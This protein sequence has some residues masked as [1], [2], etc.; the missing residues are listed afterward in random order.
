MPVQPTPI[1]PVEIKNSAAQPAEPRPIEIPPLRAPEIRP[2]EIRQTFTPQVE[3]SLAASSEI[4]VAQVAEPVLKQP[5]V[6][7]FRVNEVLVPK[8]S[9]ITESFRLA[10][11]RFSS[12]CKSAWLGL[13]SMGA[14]AKEQSLRRARSF[15]LGPRLLDAGKQGQH[16]VRGGWSRTG[17]YVRTAGGALGS[18]SRTG[19]ARMRQA[20]LKVRASSASAA[21]DVVRRA[22]HQPATPSRIRMLIAASVLRARIMAAQQLSAWRIRREQVA[23]DSRFWTSMTMAA[24]AAIIALVIVS[25]VPHYAAKSLPSRI[26]NTNPSVDAS[27]VPRAAAPAAQAKTIVPARKPVAT[28]ASHP[29][30]TKATSIMPTTSTASA[31]KARHVL[32][33]D[34]VAPNTYKYY[35]NASKPSR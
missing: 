24:I 12:V 3:G 33:D 20:S 8:S 15:E 34:Y 26:M 35:G 9:E 27:V 2:A 32:H 4:R 23:V 14:K 18:Y 7:R 11:S 17:Q 21:A 29:A 16:L 19:I 30:P 31:A 13:V 22:S 5:E 25:V 1:A 28:A 6:H 10:F